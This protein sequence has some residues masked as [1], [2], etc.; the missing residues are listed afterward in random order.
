MTVLGFLS[1]PSPALIVS[2]TYTFASSTPSSIKDMLKE[3]TTVA[4]I[5]I[6]NTDKTLFQ[7]LSLNCCRL[8]FYVFSSSLFVLCSHHCCPCN[9]PSWTI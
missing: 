1:S 3:Y 2:V 7:E 9:V 5:D 4:V 8:N 6:V